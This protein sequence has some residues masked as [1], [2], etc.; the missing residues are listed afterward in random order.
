VRSEK[1]E[2]RGERGAKQAM[3]GAG[4][5]LCSVLKRQRLEPSLSV[6]DMGLN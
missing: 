6:P 4:S 3:V 5:R 2:V 1:L